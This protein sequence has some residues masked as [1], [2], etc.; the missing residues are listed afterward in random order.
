[1]KQAAR[2]MGICAAALLLFCLLGRLTL[3][4]TYTAFVPLPEQDAAAFSPERLHIEPDVPGVLRMREPR[5]EGSYVLLP[6]EPER[7]GDVTISVSMDGRELP[8][9]VLSVDPFMTVYNHNDGGFTGDSAVLIA[10]SL[11]WLLSGLIMGWH[12]R[13]MKG[14][15]FY[16]YATI[17]YAGFSLFSFVTALTMIHVTV[18]HIVN[19]GQFN[20]LSAYYVI[21]SASTQFMVLMLPLIVVFSVSMAVSNIALLRHEKPR[22][23]NLL[24]I[25]T[26][27]LMLAGGLFGA[28]M[29][30][31][32]FAGSE[33]EFRVRNTIINTYATI[34]AYFECML[35]GSIIC[36]IRSARHVPALDKD[37]IIILGC[38]FRKDG[39]LPPLLRGR[40]DRA[41]AFWKRQRDETG[42][43]AV[44]IPSGG[45]GRNETMPEAEAMRRYLVEQGIPEHLILKEDRSANTFENMA[46]SKALI[47]ER[48][49][50]G[51]TAFSTTNYHVFRSGVWANLA[52]LSAE[53]M[54]SRTKWWFWPN[55]FM[56]ECIGLIVNRWKQEILLLVA[57]IAFFIALSFI[58]G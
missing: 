37:C 9:Q 1:M 41:I 27:L 6:I 38:W 35:I 57:L 51:R 48:N 33:W 47:Q 8:M 21:N 12:Y 43:E 30:F 53:G 49:L 42:R 45:Q 5:A 28:S 7:A 44:L 32:D 55:A 3:F 13:Q 15:A 2:Q 11:F 20:M 26:A 19:P 29:Y 22:L 52:G 36:G 34:Y 10:V 16:S 58:L 24:G 4:R 18:Q 23:K 31:S 40:V 56:R 54:G 14:S 46:N 39:T 17:Y 50:S 25:L